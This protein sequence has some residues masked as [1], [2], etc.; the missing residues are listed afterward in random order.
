LVR[1]ALLRLHI[2]VALPILMYP[3]LAGV[4]TFTVWLIFYY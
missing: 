4:F 2:K 1:L 3:S